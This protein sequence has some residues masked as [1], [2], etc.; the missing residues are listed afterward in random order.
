MAS[1]LRARNPT[2][3]SRSRGGA[4]DGLTSLPVP[5][6]TFDGEDISFALSNAN[7]SS[8]TFYL[9]PGVDTI[10]GIFLGV[11]TNGDMNF[12]VNPVPEP[13]TLSLAGLALAGLGMAW[14]RRKTNAG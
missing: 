7:Y 13:T 12:I 8:G 9:P 10:T 5:N 2:T 4:L 6:A 1:I 3:G 11:V 14:R